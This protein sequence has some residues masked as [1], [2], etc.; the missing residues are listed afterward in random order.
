[1]SKL[2]L[3]LIIDRRLD[4]ASVDCRIYLGCDLFSPACFL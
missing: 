3:L 2:Y 4:D 1:V